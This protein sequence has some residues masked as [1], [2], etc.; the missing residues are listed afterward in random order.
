M[1]YLLINLFKFTVVRVTFYNIKER[2]VFAVTKDC[3][4][5]ELLW[6]M[7]CYITY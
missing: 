6:K 4:I 1:K 5:V 3:E 2:E 7:E